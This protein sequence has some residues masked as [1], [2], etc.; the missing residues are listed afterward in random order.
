MTKTYKIFDGEKSVSLNDL[1]GWVGSADNTYGEQ[2][3]HFTKVSIVN[4]CVNIRAGK[5][6]AIPWSVVDLN[7]KKTIYTS[8]KGKLPDE[9]SFMK[10]FK[11]NL[12]LI[13]SSLCLF[14]TAFLFKQGLGNNIVGLQWLQS[15]SVDPV[16]DTKFGL[17]GFRRFVAIDRKNDS[18]FYTPDKI[19]YIRFPNPLHETLVATSPVQTVLSEA[20]V[21]LA[22]NNFTSQFIERGA[23]K[24]TVLQVEQASSPQ[25]RA[26][27]K[28]WWQK[29][30]SGIKNAWTTEVI[31][32][33][34]TP[35]IIGE[36][37]KEVAEVE[38]SMGKSK[39]IA[40]GMGVPHSLLF[41]DSANFATS[42][43][44]V[45]NFYHNTLLPD[46]MLVEEELN[47]KIFNE[48]GYYIQF[49][50]ERIQELNNDN[51]QEATAYKIFVES[52]VK[53]S[54]AVAFSGVTLPD[55]VTPEQL[56]K[57]YEEF[58]KKQQQAKQQNKAQDGI[59]SAEQARKTNG[60]DNKKQPLKEADISKF[61]KW[62]KRKLKDK[63]EFD[64]DDFDSEYLSRDE[65]KEIADSIR[66][67]ADDE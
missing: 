26:Q 34:V 47:D 8:D 15:N 32:A 37:L 66:G 20:E 14:S 43:V 7:S 58:S 57:D 36:G 2:N 9:I 30:A 63:K 29:V 12:F 44:D 45:A 25:A 5:F 39:H 18:N 23:V 56:D 59:S 50:V 11:R 6:S 60:F 41:G 27:L 67:L 24:A 31:S 54:V 17:T 62:A 1:R 28:E 55:Q 48:R 46:A 49:D 4:R 22:I 38:V 13:E 35:V 21:I 61:V 51:V 42:G 33:A 16:W 52:G 53:P 40:T 64:I 19:C 65:K 3:K 10:N